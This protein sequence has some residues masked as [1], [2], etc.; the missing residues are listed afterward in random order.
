[1]L[2]NTKNCGFDSDRESVEKTLSSIN[3]PQIIKQLFYYPYETVTDLNAFGNESYTALLLIFI[4]W[5][6][7]N[8]SKL[9]VETCQ[10]GHFK[11]K[12]DKSIGKDQ[13]KY[14]STLFEELTLAK[15]HFVDN[16]ITNEWTWNFYS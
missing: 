3:V 2:K 15:I 10:P 5:M 8:G 16:D 1:M 11:I 14:F 7:D 4:I 6:K 9:V 13:I 12:I